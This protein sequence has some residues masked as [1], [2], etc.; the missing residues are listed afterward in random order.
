MR[1]ERRDKVAL[2]SLAD[3][4]L[5]CGWA[6]RHPHLEWDGL[7]MMSVPVNVKCVLADFGEF[8]LLD[9]QDEIAGQKTG[10]FAHLYPD[11][12]IDIRHDRCA[13]LVHQIHL[14][15]MGSV[16]VRFE[17]YSKRDRT[18]WMHG[19]QFFG[20]DRIECPKH[21]EFATIIRRRVT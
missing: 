9:V 16:L 15:L 13:I 21:T 17:N 20:D 14:E 6:G 11:G 5:S 4:A 19:R 3:L 2:L 8:E 10:D 12:N 7:F 18:L 1:D